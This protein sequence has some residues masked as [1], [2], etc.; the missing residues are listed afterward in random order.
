MLDNCEQ[1]GIKFTLGVEVPY[2][3]LQPTKM[4]YYPRILNHEINYKTENGIR[5]IL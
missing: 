5:V 2:S 1:L 3:I 4:K